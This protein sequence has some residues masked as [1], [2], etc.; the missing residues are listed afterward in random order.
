MC[1]WLCQTATVCTHDQAL[2]P[3]GGSTFR[4]ARPRGEQVPQRTGWD[5]GLRGAGAGEVSAQPEISCDS[6]PWAVSG[7]KGPLRLLDLKWLPAAGKSLAPSEAGLLVPVAWLQ[8]RTLGLLK[9]G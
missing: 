5:A 8:L 9:S 3:L 4:P 2:V 7:S 1:R 6:W